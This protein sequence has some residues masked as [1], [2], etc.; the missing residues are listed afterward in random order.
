MP[1]DELRHRGVGRRDDEAA[2]GNFWG[3]GYVHYL[4]YGDS[5]T[6]YTNVKTYQIVLFR[7]LQYVVCQMVNFFQILS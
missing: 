5:F 7:Y 1:G 3:N 6:N 2:R 4:D